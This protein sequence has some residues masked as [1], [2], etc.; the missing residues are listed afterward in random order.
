[1]KRILIAGPLD[2]TSQAFVRQLSENMTL[3][4]TVYTPSQVVLPADVTGF[5]GE[6]MDEGGL[7][8]AM[9]DQ[10][11]VVALA[12]TI[13]L[14]EIVKAVVTAAQAVAVPQVMVSRTDDI[15]DLPRE[16]RTAQQL[17]LRA[18]MPTDLVEG[19]GSLSALLGLDVLPAPTAVDPLFDARFAG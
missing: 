4:L 18:G 7:S 8:A 9:L 1:M 2:P 14:V 16:V 15:D 17:L 19:F 13:H 5:T 3:D 11:L 10:D 12:P 6:T